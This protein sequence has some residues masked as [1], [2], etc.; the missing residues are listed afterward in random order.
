MVSRVS[1]AVFLEQFESFAKDNIQ[2][3]SSSISIIYG[4]CPLAANSSVGRINQLLESRIGS[5]ST[6]ILGHFSQLLV[7]VLDRIGCVNNKLNRLCVS[8]ISRKMLSIL[9]SLTDG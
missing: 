8:K 7:V 3:M 5:E 6:L 1:Q 2:L 9:L 4:H